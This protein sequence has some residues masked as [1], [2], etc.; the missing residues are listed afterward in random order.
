MDTCVWCAYAHVFYW[1][2]LTD[3]KFAEAR[4]SIPPL[5]GSMNRLDPGQRGGT[6]GHQEST[7]QELAA[8]PI[9]HGHRKIMLTGFYSGNHT[10]LRCLGVSEG[11][12]TR[13]LQ[14][15][16]ANCPLGLFSYSDPMPVF[17]IHVAVM[18]KRKVPHKSSVPF[19]IKSE[20]LG[21]KLYKHSWH[22]VKLFR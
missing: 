20:C 21:P 19:A 16:G 10:I 5:G 17:S 9:M 4:I 3:H 8:G 2:T 15:P 6:L 13:P 12:R 18:W 14:I 22:A 7:P 11:L 1:F